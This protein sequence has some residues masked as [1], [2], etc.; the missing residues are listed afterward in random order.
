VE[1]DR[2]HQGSVD[3]ENHCLDRNSSNSYL[4]FY[5]PRFL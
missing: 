4:G 3:I 5:K 1:V 2:I